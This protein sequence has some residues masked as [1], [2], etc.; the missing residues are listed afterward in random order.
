MSSGFEFLLVVS[1]SLGKVVVHVHGGL[2]G[3]TAPALKERLLDIIDGQGN[4]QVVLDLRRM[5]GVNFAGLS[6]LVDAVMRMGECGGEL[7]LSSPT[8]GVLEQLQA[9]GLAEVAVITPEW[10][11]PARGRTR[12]RRTWE[13]DSSR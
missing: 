3:R 11:H 1:R 7:V 10:T 8:R 4:R 12:A 9:A 5:T 13:N 2:D 6:V